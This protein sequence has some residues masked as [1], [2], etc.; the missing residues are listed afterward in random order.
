M[1]N[2]SKWIGAGILTAIASSACCIVP[3]LA[4]ISGTTGA[5]SNMEWLQP[6]RP[7]L[8]LFTVLVLSYSW[9]QKLKPKKVTCTCDSQ[10]PSFWQSKLFLAI[11]T[12]FAIVMTFFPFFSATMLKS[13]KK[14][15]IYVKTENL[16]TASFDIKG[17]TCASCEEHINHSVN[18]IKGVT[19][20][21]SSYKQ[22]KTTIEY[23]KTKTDL[24]E[25]KKAIT[26]TGYSIKK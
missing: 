11:V 14:E 22:G 12:V 6:I 2:N 9:Y 19:K 21:N 26:K 4:L 7:Y 3:F 17:M 10:K 18:E 5:A 20:V 13:N 23:D 16:Q 1:K 25:I 24:N 15:V 8:I